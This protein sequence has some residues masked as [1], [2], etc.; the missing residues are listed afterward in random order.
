MIEL[1]SYRICFVC[2]GNICRSPMADVI[3]RSLVADHELGSDVVVSSA[4]TGSWHVGDGADPRAIRALA[5][6]GYD[7]SA[8]LAQQFDPTWF[9]RLDLVVAL[10]SGHVRAL[11]ALAPSAAHRER[12]VLLG[13]FTPGS[14]T[15]GVGST[16]DPGVTPLDVADPYFGDDAGFADCLAQIQDACRGLVERLRARDLVSSPPLAPGHPSAPK[17]AL[18]WP[19]GSSDPPPGGD[20]ELPPTLDS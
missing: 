18:E 7:G 6:A 9:D 12:V 11:R 1:V 8:H 13:S 5:D 4:G 17:A 14:F 19:V 15:P 16:A 20:R 2:T 10:D 3:T